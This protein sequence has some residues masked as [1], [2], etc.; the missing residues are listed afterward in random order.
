[1]GDGEGGAVVKRM[2]RL[3]VFR[4][5]AKAEVEESFDWFES[6]RSGLGRECMA[7]LECVLDSVFLTP[8]LF[9]FVYGELRKA[10]LRR[11]TCVVLFVESVTEVLVLSLFH[12]K[13]NSRR[14]EGKS[15]QIKRGVFFPVG[16]SPLLAR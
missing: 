5:E 13:R 8:Q 15:C 14:L 7:S 1:M 4:S 12:T 6:E 9:S 16:S 3:L 10:L 11:L 2:S